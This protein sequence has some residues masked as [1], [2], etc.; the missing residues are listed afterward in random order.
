[1]LQLGNILLQSIY[2]IPEVF[3]CRFEC[4]WSRYDV[5]AVDVNNL[6]MELRQ[7]RNTR[8]FHLVNH[9][10]SINFRFQL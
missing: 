4:L 10:I 3:R 5:H 1:M 9:N 6:N 7:S 2:S 8:N